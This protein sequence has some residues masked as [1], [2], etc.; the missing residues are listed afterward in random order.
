[1]TDQQ[2]YIALGAPIL[3]NGVLLTVIVLY[4]NAKLDGMMH[5]MNERFKGID[6]RLDGMNQRF[7]DLRDLWRAELHRVE[8]VLGAPEAPRRE[9]NPPHLLAS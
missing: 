8:E 5:L 2:L 1:M 7:D 6:A 4:I 9:I 3:F